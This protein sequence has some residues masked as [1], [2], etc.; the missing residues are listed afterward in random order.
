MLRDSNF[1]VQFTAV[2]GLADMHDHAASLLDDLL[3]LV[4]SGDPDLDIW[5]AVVALG[6]EV[7]SAA[8]PHLF[9]N[10][11]NQRIKLYYCASIAADLHLQSDA[12]LK[13]LEEGLSSESPQIAT[14]LCQLATDQRAA[15]TQVIK[16]TEEDRLTA[17]EAIKA[18]QHS[19]GCEDLLVPFFRQ[20]LRSDDYWTRYD[21]IR[22]LGKL[23]ASAEPTLDE[24][25]SQLDDDQRGMRL[26]AAKSIFLISG[27]SDILTRELQNALNSHDDNSLSDHAAAIEIITELGSAGAP[28]LHIVLDELKSPE[29]VWQVTD[30]VHALESIRTEQ[31]VKALDDMANSTDWIFR[32]KAT[33]ALQRIRDHVDYDEQEEFD[34]AFEDF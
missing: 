19:S 29:T 12:V 34:E 6:P 9:A 15:T 26:Q 17:R 8:E 21:A 30:G 13:K 16:A 20:Y 28:Y 31:A 32:S 18:L 24:M 14:A 4:D 7:G 27:D 10:L 5:S 11:Q 33:R 1:E 2:Q 3:Q 22:A 25:K 23:G